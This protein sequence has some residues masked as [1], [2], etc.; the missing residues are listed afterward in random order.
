MTFLAHATQAYALTKVVTSSEELAIASAIIATYPDALT[1]KDQLDNSW[2]FY[3]KMHDFKNPLLFIF[4]F[5]AWLHAF[6]DLF[7]HSR[8]GDWYWWTYVLESAWWLFFI[9]SFII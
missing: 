4:A 7:T 1:F 9:H 6:V 3:L 5:P 8:L 2:G